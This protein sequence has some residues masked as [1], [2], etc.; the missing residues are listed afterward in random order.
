MKLIK[1]IVITLAAIMVFAN[2][3]FAK[4]P[5]AVPPNMIG[6]ML[7]TTG[8]DGKIYLPGQVDIGNESWSGF[9]NRLVLIQR[10]GYYIK[11]QFL[12][13]VDGDEEDH[14][15][16]VGPDR[17]PMTLD[18]RLLFA[19]PN[20]ETAEGKQAILRMGLLGN[21]VP[22][23]DSA[24]LGGNRVMLL[25]A[26]SIY[27]EQVRNQVRGKI[28][29]VCLSND[30]VEAVYQSLEKNGKNGFSDIIQAAVASVLAEN[31]SPLL[32]VA[33]VVSNAKPDPEVVQAIV[34]RKAAEQLV[35]AMVT[36]DNFIKEDSTGTRAEIFKLM[37]MQGIVTNNDG[38][39]TMFMTDIGGNPNIV[40]IPVQ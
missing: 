14:R 17:E 26:E 21:P 33:A 40:P 15:C 19:M 12:E 4:Q 29:D 16:V 8:Y 22:H 10:S 38:T 6:L 37:V 18:V 31:D 32:L 25:Q 35:Q 36:I 34:A 9:G 5:R 13:H 3:S 20:P 28:R 7:T 39:N 1:S 2:P 24:T 30:S 11:E 27:Q 23:P